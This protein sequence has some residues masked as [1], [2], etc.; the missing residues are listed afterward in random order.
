LALRSS[1]VV[2]MGFFIIFGILNIVYAITIS[3]L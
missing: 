1:N 3:G 2:R